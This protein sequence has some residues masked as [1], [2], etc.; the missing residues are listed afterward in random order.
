MKEKLSVIM[1]FY[2]ERPSYVKTNIESIL[3]Q[4]YKDFKFIIVSDNPQNE[5]LNSIATIYAKRDNRIIFIKNEKNLGIPKTKNRAL[6]LCETEYIAISD[7]DDYSHPE[8]LSKQIAYLDSHKDVTAIGCYAR[9][10]DEDGKIVGE[11]HT[12]PDDKSLKTML[13]FQQPIYHPAMVF[14]RIVD[15][16][17]VLYDENMKISLDYE[18]CVSLSDGKFHNIPEYLLDYRLSPGQ[19]SQVYKDEYIVYDSPVRTRALKKFYYGL[20]DAEIHAFIQMYYNQK[21]TKSEILL[22]E[23]FIGNL[24]INNKENT[25]VCIKK[26]IDYLIN[27]YFYCLRHNS[28]I[29]FTFERIIYLYNRLERKYIHSVLFLCG[30][31][32]RSLRMKLLKI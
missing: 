25:S 30:C 11:A 9:L 17:K 7:A 16:K 20:N 14:R 12:A 2:N 28:S 6:A 31:A 22:A 15:G 21:M 26:A 13:P 19:T 8:R 3:N 10:I 4:T 24:Y 1:A 23:S 27:S 5:D 32:I 18:L 29:G